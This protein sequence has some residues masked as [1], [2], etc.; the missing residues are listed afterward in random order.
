MVSQLKRFVWEFE[1]NLKDWGLGFQVAWDVG[2]WRPYWNI[3]VGPVQ[4][5][6]ARQVPHKPWPWS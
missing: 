4:F 5:W 3:Q 1:F 2:N 6:G